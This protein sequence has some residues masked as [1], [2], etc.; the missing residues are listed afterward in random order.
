M[1]L[2]SVASAWAFGPAGR[3]GM[4]LHQLSSEE[5]HIKDV[6]QMRSI[7]RT[8][9]C[10]VGRSMYVG[11][12]HVLFKLH[13]GRQ[14][15][16][17]ALPQHLVLSCKQFELRPRSPSKKKQIP[18]KPRSIPRLPKGFSYAMLCMEGGRDVMEQ[19]HGRSMPRSPKQI[20][21]PDTST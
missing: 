11:H 1:E 9:F 7:A 20:L 19:N 5:P 17:K 2:A 12:V 3:S 13:A 10:R 18:K 16:M 15:P 8:S 6:C 14:R 4:L 21:T